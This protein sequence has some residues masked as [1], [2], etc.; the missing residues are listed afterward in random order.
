M[1]RRRIVRRALIGLGIGLTLWHIAEQVMPPFA[2]RDVV[3]IG[4]YV[5]TYVVV[6]IWLEAEPKPASAG[7]IK[8]SNEEDHRG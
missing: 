4:F 2:W 6:N 5:P 3:W 7:E 1:N 8:T